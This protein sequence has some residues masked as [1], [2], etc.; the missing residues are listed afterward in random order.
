[1]KTKPLI[2]NIYAL[3]FLAI[4]I[5]IPVQVSMIYGHGTAELG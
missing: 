5:S 4:A 2:F 3:L 1:M